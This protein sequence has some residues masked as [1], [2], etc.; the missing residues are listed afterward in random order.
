MRNLKQ[1]VPEQ[2]P[3]NFGT[4]KRPKIALPGKALAGDMR[5]LK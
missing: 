3:E 5:N 2:R 1:H 4:P